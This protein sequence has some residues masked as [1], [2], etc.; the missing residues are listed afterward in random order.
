M[1]GVVLIVEDEAQILELIAVN[2][3]HAGQVPWRARSV[4][5]PKR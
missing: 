3:E 4:K 5:K 2:V 1:P